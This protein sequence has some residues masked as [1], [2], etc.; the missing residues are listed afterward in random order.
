M[1]LKQL[2]QSAQAEQQF[3]QMQ[4]WASQ[5]SEMLPGADF[6]AVSLPDLM[7][8]DND[9]QQAH[10]QHCLLVTA[11]AQLGLGQ[12]AAAQQ[13][14]SELLAINPAHDKARLFTVLAETL[15]N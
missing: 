2:G 9:L 14:L 1:A 4:Q 15:A 7:A 8:L 13:T 10:Q 5:Q 3:T 11:L 12:L 6:F